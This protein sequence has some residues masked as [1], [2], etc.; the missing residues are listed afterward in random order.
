MYM[1]ALAGQTD[2]PKWL[3]IFEG[4]QGFLGPGG[5]VD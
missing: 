3:N 1:L 4:T 2:G 5:N